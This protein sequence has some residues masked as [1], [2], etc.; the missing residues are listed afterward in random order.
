[1]ATRTYISVILPLKLEWEPCYALPESQDPGKVRTVEQEP[2]VRVGDRVKV[3]FARK[4]YTG[5]VSAVGIEPETELHKIKE[6]VTVENGLERIRE[7]EIALW[8][9]VAG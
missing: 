3:E 7:E 5:V 8:R 2:V 9:R 1:M 4:A 6:I